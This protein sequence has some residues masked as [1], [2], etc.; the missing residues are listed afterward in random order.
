MLTLTNAPSQ[1]AASRAEF[2]HI[3]PLCSLYQIHQDQ[4]L[5]DT[6]CGAGSSIL[7]TDVAGVSLVRAGVAVDIF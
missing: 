4:A 6:L 1:Q 7:G 5:R 3:S 2:S